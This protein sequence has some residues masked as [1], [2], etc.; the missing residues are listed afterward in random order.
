MSLLKPT[1]LKHAVIIFGLEQILQLLSGFGIAVV[2][3][4]ALGPHIY[5]EVKL[6]EFMGMLALYIGSLGMVRTLGRFVPAWRRDGHHRAAAQL[7]AAAF[8]LC[9][10]VG[11]ILLVVIWMLRADMA[12]WFEAPRLFEQYLLPLVLFVMFTLLNMLNQSWLQSIE[13]RDLST[14]AI[15]LRRFL[16]VSAIGVGYLLG[17]NIG[18]VLWLLVVGA[19]VEFVLEFQWSVRSIRLLWQK[20]GGINQQVRETFP[21]LWRYAL[22]MAGS[23]GLVVLRDV[24]FAG[25][26]LGWL[27]D[28]AAV[29]VF[30]V[31]VM[32]PNLL[33]LFSPNKL[34]GGILVTR[35]STMDEEAQKQSMAKM[36]ALQQQLNYLLWVP[37]LL[38]LALTLP[39][40]VPLLFGAA[41]ADSVLVGQVYVLVVALALTFGPMQYVLMLREQNKAV[42]FQYALGLLNVPLFFLLTPKV[43]AVGVVIST[44]F[45]SLL[46][47]LS[48]LW[49]LRPL[50]LVNAGLCWSSL[51]LAL[52]GAVLIGVIFFMSVQVFP[53]IVG[54][55]L[56]GLGYG[57]FL[58]WQKPFNAGS[59]SQLH[60]ILQVLEKSV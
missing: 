59:L 32:L 26:M 2:L 4:R 47:W 25:F 33:Y 5:G 53:V 21:R 51:R 42:L 13:R 27:V 18:Y 24:A 8:G 44:A 9:V 23:N 50:Q 16:V 14:V 41:Y 7:G 60:P 43:G 22:T 37:A 58:L 6:F 31:G 38:G 30:S 3:A 54:G 11:F 29:A 34:L 46:I 55:V 19:A 48:A 56:A 35:Q 52:V 20:G 49:F 40:W 45:V 17:L 36:L 1:P 15:L 10:L 28:S 57:L 39:F 12:T